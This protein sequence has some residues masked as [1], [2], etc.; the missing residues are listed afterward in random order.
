VYKQDM[1]TRNIKEY[2]I[3]RAS[4]DLISR[5]YKMPE[6]PKEQEKLINS[7]PQCVKRE[8][9]REVTCDA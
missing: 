8:W 5:G 7:I 6:D 3:N 9:V 1:T 2:I 4:K